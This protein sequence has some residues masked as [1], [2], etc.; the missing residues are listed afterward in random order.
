MSKLREF[1]IMIARLYQAIIE[2]F[3]PAQ[4]DKDGE[5]AK[6]ARMFLISHTMGPILGN[7]VPLAL[8]V[9]DPTPDY[10]VFVLAL[11]ITGFWI[12]P[13]L[14]KS[15]VNYDLLVITSVINLNFCILWSCYHYGGVASPTMPWLLI[16]PILSLFY[17]GGE[18]RLQPLLLSISAVAFGLFFAAYL[19]IDPPAPD[20]AIEALQGLGIV[21]TIAALCYV[22]T[23]AIYYSRIFNAGLDLENE[24]SRR[25]KVAQ[26]LRE[27]VTA[28]DG[29]ASA[30]AD[31]LASMSHELRT[32]LNAVIGYSDMLLEDATD[33]ND[34]R[35]VKDVN[36]ISEAA[37]YLLR[38]LNM[39]L[40][41]SKIEAGHMQFKK[42]DNDVKSVLESIVT[43]CQP[44]LDRQGNKI[45]IQTSGLTKTVSFDVD[46]VSQVLRL[47]VRNACEHTKDGTIMLIAG[48][49]TK[50]KTSV[51]RLTVADTGAG[52]SKDQLDTIFNALVNSKEASDSRYGGSGLSMTFAHRMCYAMGGSLNVTSELGKGSRFTIE[53]PI[54]SETAD[55]SDEFGK[56]QIERLAA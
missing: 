17:I 30:K 54:E 51:L 2:Y 14:L 29:A 37:H 35:V 8:Y 55:S 45:T 15:G 27:A 52:M 39:I 3:V 19:I 53:L 4:L 1:G 22:A 12:F 21:S 40:D 46:K 24:V 13:S 38:L 31:F 26:E 7:S 32:P 50:Q 23:M 49:G 28:A 16:I 43:D 20:M 34:K 48:I 5:K 33:A 36:Q 56:D 25:M 44:S 11:S 47:I 42:E 18:K 41:L 10:A 9:F 6:Q